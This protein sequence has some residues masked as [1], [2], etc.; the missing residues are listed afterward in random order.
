MPQN[1]WCPAQDWDLPAGLTGANPNGTANPS[2]IFGTGFCPGKCIRSGNCFSSESAEGVPRSSV[3]SLSLYKKTPSNPRL[4]IAR[5]LKGITCSLFFP[6]IPSPHP[7]FV[8]FE[9]N[10]VGDSVLNIKPASGIICLWLISWSWHQWSLRF[11]YEIA[12]HEISF[13]RCSGHTCWPLWWLHGS[14]L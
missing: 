4:P 11:P 12:R 7:P 8:S 9:F 13:A 5:D 2:S 1:W 6:H 3:V 14:L 10:K